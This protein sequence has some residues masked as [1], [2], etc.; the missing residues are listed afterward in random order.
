MTMTLGWAAYIQIIYKLVKYIFK[1]RY[2]FL[3]FYHK[4]EQQTENTQTQQTTNNKQITMPFLQLASE[5]EQPFVIPSLPPVTSEYSSRANSQ[6][7]DEEMIKRDLQL[8][9][10]RLNK[11]DESAVVSDEEEEQEVDGYRTSYN[12][13]GQRRTSLCLL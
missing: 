4:S 12:E 2:I 9:Q 3:T 7:V 10:T 13:L 5:V 11:L 6:V 8:L 1:L